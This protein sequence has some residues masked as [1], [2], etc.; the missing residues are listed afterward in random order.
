MSGVQTCALPISFLAQLQ[1]DG[2]RRVVQRLIIGITQYEG[3]I[4]DAFAIHVV[5]G[6]ATTSTNTN[7]LDDAIFFFGLAKVEQYVIIHLF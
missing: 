4:V 3:N 2:D 5:D 1:M 6:V 7:H